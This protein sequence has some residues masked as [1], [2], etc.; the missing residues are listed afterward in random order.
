MN[1]VLILFSALS[2]LAYGSACFVSS[3]MRREFERYHLGSQRKLVGGLQVLAG[4][5][6]LA[7]LSYP[8]MGQAASAGLALMM[9]IAVGV[10]IRIKDTLLQTLPALIYLALNGYLSLGAFWSETC[11]RAP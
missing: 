11:L 10:R 4:M 6:L 7:G 2:F 8:W 5:G 1:V 3:Q 9:M